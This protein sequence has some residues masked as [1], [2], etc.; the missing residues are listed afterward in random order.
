MPLHRTSVCLDDAG[1]EAYNS[2]DP[3][4]RSGVIRDMLITRSPQAVDATNLKARLA[5]LDDQLSHTRVVLTLARELEEINEEKHTL[6]TA[7]AERLRAI[8]IKACFLQREVNGR[9]SADVFKRALKFYKDFSEEVLTVSQVEA[10]L[11]ALLAK[12][13]RHA[14]E[15]E[16]KR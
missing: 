12:P 2:I 13:K 1:F 7:R 6:D 3:Y 11:D 15:E 9:A 10:E 5:L 4:K 8:A 16:A 14:E